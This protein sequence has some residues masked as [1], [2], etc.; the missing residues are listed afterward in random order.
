MTGKSLGNAPKADW[1]TDA[2]TQQE[3][4]K[5]LCSYFTKVGNVSNLMLAINSDMSHNT[6]KVEE[7]KQVNLFLLL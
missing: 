2:E 1:P 5:T 6:Y 7:S 4:A 3:D